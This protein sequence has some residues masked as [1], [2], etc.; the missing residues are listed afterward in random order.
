MTKKKVKEPTI[1][2][3]TVMM[4]LCG[5]SRTY[6]SGTAKCIIGIASN[7]VYTVDIVV[8]RFAEEVA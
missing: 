8:K 3:S 6:T 1:P 7:E 2:L 4:L 5:G